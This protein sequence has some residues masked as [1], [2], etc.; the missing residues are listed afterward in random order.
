LFLSVFCFS[1]IINLL[2]PSIK[3][4][5]EWF[6]LIIAIVLKQQEPCDLSKLFGGSSAIRRTFVPIVAKPSLE[7]PIA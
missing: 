7:P 1:N 5:S 2:A 4:D 3:D 6:V